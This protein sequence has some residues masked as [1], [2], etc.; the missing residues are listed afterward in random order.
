MKITASGQ[1]KSQRKRQ[2][3]RDGINSV[4][5]EILPYVR[6]RAQ[7]IASAALE[8]LTASTLRFI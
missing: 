8:A 7:I 2:D 1:K 6:M 3:Q 4:K 5:P